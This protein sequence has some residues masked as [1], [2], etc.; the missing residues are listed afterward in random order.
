MQGRDSNYSAPFNEYGRSGSTRPPQGPPALSTSGA[1]PGSMPDSFG[2]SSSNYASHNQPYGQPQDGVNEDSLKAYHDT[3]TG[4]SPSL[5]QPGRTSSAA[6]NI[7]QQHSQSNYPPSQSHQQSYGG[8][9]SHSNPPHS[10]QGSQYGGLGGLGGLGGQQGT[11][12]AHQG[13]G[14]YSGYGGG[15]GN[16]SYGNYGRGGW[17]GNYQGH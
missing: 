14:G 12:Q 16:S 11:A 17:G 7:G 13:G 4:P 8:Y 15:F 2:R 10:N 1:F 9:P 5:G 3:K 6:N